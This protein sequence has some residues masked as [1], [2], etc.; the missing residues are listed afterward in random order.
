MFTESNRI[1]VVDD[2]KDELSL[3]ANEFNKKGIGCRTIEYDGF[4]FP[5]HPFTGVRIAFF[6]INLTSANDDSQRFSVLRDAICKYISKDNGPYVLIFW[7]NQRDWKDKFIDYVNRDKSDSNI[8]RKH[9]KPFYVSTIDKTS[10]S[11]DNTLEK[12][13][14]EEFDNK[15]VELCLNF[16]RQLLISSNLT[17]SKL[18]SIIPIDDEWGR[19]YSYEN[20]FKNLFSKIAI[21]SYGL[22]NAKNNVSQAINDAIIP[23]IAASMPSTNLWNEYLNLNS[24]TA[25]DVDKLIESDAINKLNGFFFIDNKKSFDRRGCVIKLKESEFEKITRK[26][27]Q[28]WKKDEFGDDKTIDNAYPIAIEISPACDDCQNNPRNFKYLLGIASNK[29]KLKKKRDC[30]LSLAQFCYDRNEY[31]IVLDFNYIVVNIQESQYDSI[32]FNLK[33]EIMDMIGNRYANHI[34]RIGITSFR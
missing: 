15:M 11:N 26:S 25:K 19:P 22:E 13:L 10:I 21:E 34:S 16:D 31:Q 4:D 24:I 5:E 14:H 29:I 8:L 6:D 33:K 32:L 18:L 30:F 28:D 2:K 20:N 9:L 17:I 3:I 1:I 23:I 12:M 7:T 27:F